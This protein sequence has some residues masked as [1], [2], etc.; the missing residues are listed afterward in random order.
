M[1][2]MLHISHDYERFYTEHL[3]ETMLKTA[4]KAPGLFK[5][6]NN[7]CVLASD[8]AVFG[9]YPAMQLAHHGNGKMMFQIP[10]QLHY[11][12]PGY[13]N[14]WEEVVMKEDNL[15]EAQVGLI[16]PWRALIVGDELA[17]I[18]ESNLIEN[19][20]PPSNLENTEWIEPGVAVFS[21]WGNSLANDDPAI[22]KDY[23]DMAAEM[24]WEWLEFDIGLLG[25]QGGYAVNLWRDTDY[26]PITEIWFS[27]FS[28]QAN[29]S[30]ISGY[31]CWNNLYL[32]DFM[33]LA[34]YFT[35]RADCLL[36]IKSTSFWSRVTQ[37]KICSF[38]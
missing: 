30:G 9:N 32:P 1:K 24:N 37:Y 13:K 18:V 38:E 29:R 28:M 12:S 23:I 4:Y 7:Q 15:V 31:V 8:A 17:D 10:Q 19:L 26:I 2:K 14:T 33:F 36:I 27:L 6:P 16:T 21:W 5:T 22:L 11:A 20:N 3:V 34:L 25:N 35:S